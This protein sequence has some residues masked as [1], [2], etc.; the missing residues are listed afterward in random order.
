MQD[1]PVLISREGLDRLQAE[2]DALRTTRRA[3]IAER[4]SYAKD[5]GEIAEN[6]EYEDAK[7]EQGMVEGRILV[8]EKMI[9][10]AVLIEEGP[11]GGHVVVGSVVTVEDESGKQTFT[12][13]GP[14]EA[15]PSGGRISL[16]SPVGRALMGRRKGDV[17]EVSTPGGGRALKITK[18][19]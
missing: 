10:N 15:D 3:E 1:R 18:I 17:V 14:A 5:F 7:N 4:I 12:I 16:E 8:L 19:G 11:S 13:V 6:A 2:L 9:R